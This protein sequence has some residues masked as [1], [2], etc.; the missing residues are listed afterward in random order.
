[1]IKLGFVKNYWENEPSSKFGYDKNSVGDRTFKLRKYSV[2]Q[3]KSSFKGEAKL[4][5]KILDH[6]M[7]GSSGV[8]SVRNLKL[9]LTAI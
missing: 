2:T 4:C 5:A 7:S 1:M 6:L 9:Y 8:V 3:N